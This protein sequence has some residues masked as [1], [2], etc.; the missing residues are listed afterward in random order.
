MWVEKAEATPRP[1]ATAAS[2][3]EVETQQALLRE[4]EAQLAAEE[5][6]AA[7]ADAHR[8]MLRKGEERG[9]SEDTSLREAQQAKDRAQP[10]AAAAC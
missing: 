8:A 3:R 4:A 5:R 2:K 1:P 9:A 6:G 7:G 10:V